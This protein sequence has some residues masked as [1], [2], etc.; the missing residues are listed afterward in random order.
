MAGIVTDQPPMQRTIHYA[1]DKPRVPPPW[2]AVN[3][4]KPPAAGG[5]GAIAKAVTENPVVVAVAAGARVNPTVYEVGDDADEEAVAGEIGGEG[6][7]GGAEGGEGGVP[8][9]PQLPAVFIG[10]SLVGGLDRLMAVHI[11]GELVPILRDAGAL[12]L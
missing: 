9:T 5:S 10:G 1:Q 2:P 11:S 3:G 12:W 8:A 6:N 7:G 4:D